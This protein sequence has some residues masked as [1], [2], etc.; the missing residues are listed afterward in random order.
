MRAKHRLSPCS[1]SFLS[2]SQ[3]VSPGVQCFTASFPTPSSTLP[4]SPYLRFFL[5]STS[6]QNVDF[7]FP[8]LQNKKKS[9]PFLQNTLLCTLKFSKHFL[10]FLKKEPQNLIL[11]NFIPLL[12]S[13]WDVEFPAETVPFGISL[14]KSLHLLVLLVVNGVRGAGLLMEGMHKTEFSVTCQNFWG[15]Q[16]WRVLRSAKGT[17]LSFFRLL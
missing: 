14:G 1:P 6:F 9:S 8:V 11:A 16:T 13:G 5:S 12:S 3:P 10:P 2:V 17:K 15:P 7:S 4:I